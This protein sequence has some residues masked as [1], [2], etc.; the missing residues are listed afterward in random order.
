MEG[1]NTK[2][3][4]TYF[5]IHSFMTDELDLSGAELL[6]YALIYSFSDSE[7]GFHGSQDYISKRTALS[8][9]SIAYATS[10][11]V[12]KGLIT[13]E[14][15]SGSRNAKYKATDTS[16]LQNLQTEDAKIAEATCKNC[17]SQLQ[18]LQ[19]STAKIASNNKE[20]NKRYNKEYNSAHEGAKKSLKKKWGFEG[21][22]WDNPEWVETVFEQA[23]ARSYAE[24]D[25]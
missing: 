10:S 21:S 9:R 19:K 23:L 12:E 6:I 17:K 24:L 1:I 4:G 2:T 16:R 15:Q 14:K 13:K 20:Y 11:L 8:L 5:S 7:E 25:D 22:N 3:S 18:N